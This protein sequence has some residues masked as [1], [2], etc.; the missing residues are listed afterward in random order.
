MNQ[1][2][3]SISKSSKSS[4]KVYKGR[5]Y[6]CSCRTYEQA[7]YVRQEL[8]KNNWDTDK[9]EDI[10]KEYPKYYTKLLFFYQYVHYSKRTNKWLILIP[11]TKS[12]SQKIQHLTY[13]NPEDALFE[14]DFLMEHNWDYELLVECIDDTTNPY[15]NM[16]LPPY[17]ER[18]IRN[19][20]RGK[21]HE[22]ELLI[23]QEK[24]LEDPDISISAIAKKMS[25]A[26]QSIR[27]WLK[28]YNTDFLDFKTVVLR[29][30]DPLQTFTLQE[31]IYTPD[32]SPSKANF[33]NYVSHNNRS[34]TNPYV[35]VNNKRESFGWYP[36]RKIAEKIAKDLAK[37]NW[38]RNKLP[39][40][41][42]KYNFKPIQK[43]RNY[44]YPH[45]KKFMVQKQINNKTIRFGTYQT[46]PIAESIRDKLMACDWDKNQL[47]DI[48]C[49]VAYEFGGVLH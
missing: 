12:E 6:I 37:C 8:R 15:Y 26:P 17:P 4:Y 41:Q 11:K 16:T 38:D 5:E 3:G 14:R 30:E 33:K 35:I 10:L 22:N 40:I 39:K 24:V 23:M 21:S 13:N 29:G 28:K 47:S 1:P 44:I 19:V 7:H 32:L 36:N 45:G 34:K 20:T 27:N 48:Q 46:L 9:L 42:A 25:C 49:E 43:R 18:R 31:K 2:K